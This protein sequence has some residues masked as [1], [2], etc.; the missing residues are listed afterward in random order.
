MPSRSLMIGGAKCAL[1]EWTA[2]AD[3]DWLQELY[4]PA[5]AGASSYTPGDK[6]VRLS[7]VCNGQFA[8]LHRRTK[9]SSFN[10]VLSFVG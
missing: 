7:L 8:V 10:I 3:G 4:P 6:A 9:N 2:L 5:A 1:V